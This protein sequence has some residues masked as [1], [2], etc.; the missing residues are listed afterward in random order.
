[1]TYNGRTTGYVVLTSIMA[2]SG[3]LMFYDV[4]ISGGVTSMHSFLSKFFP[5]VLA[6]QGTGNKYCK[7]SNQKL[8]LFTSSL[9]IA[10]LIATFAAGYTPRRFGRLLTMRVTAPALY[11]VII[12]RVI[13]DIGVGFANQAV[14]L[15]LLEMAPTNLRGG[16]N[17]LFQLAVTVGIFVANLANYGTNKI[18]GC[19]W[20]LALGGAG[21]PACLLAIGAIV[22]LDTPNSLIEQG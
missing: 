20:R 12:G 19:G 21:V 15:Y 7:Y 13:L 16:L 4:G 10:E 3:G 2:A 22:L 14:P 6:K 1:M 11:V 18:K 5:K 9:Y 17:I 8:Q